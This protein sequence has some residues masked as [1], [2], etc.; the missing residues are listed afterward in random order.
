MASPFAERPIATIVSSHGAV[1]SL[2]ATMLFHACKISSLVT[3]C[4]KACASICTSSIN[5][6]NF[7][8][9]Y[10]NRLYLRKLSLYSVVSRILQ[11]RKGHPGDGCRPRHS[12]RLNAKK[13]SPCTCS[14]DAKILTQHRCSCKPKTEHI[15]AIIGTSETRA[16]LARFLV[17]RL[18]RKRANTR[19][20]NDRPSRA[21]AKGRI[22]FETAMR[23][24]WLL[25]PTSPSNGFAEPAGRQARKFRTVRIIATLPRSHR[26][27]WGPR[28]PDRWAT[29]NRRWPRSSPG[30]RGARARAKRAACRP[31]HARRAAA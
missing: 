28:C 6:S 10:S 30:C 19:R 9:R 29:C 26:R 31:R 22:A 15:F 20:Q 25:G 21:Y 13:E 4:L 23:P 18:R 14:Y 8:Q 3:P 16:D 17:I 24:W 2:M 11:K 5:S 7:V 1:L 27:A 12:R